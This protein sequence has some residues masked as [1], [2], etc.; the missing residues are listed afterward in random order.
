MREVFR[1][2]GS[3]RTSR[4]G[5]IADTTTAT[6]LAPVSVPNPPNFCISFS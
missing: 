5:E 6:T 3:Y 1:N 2:I 4:Q